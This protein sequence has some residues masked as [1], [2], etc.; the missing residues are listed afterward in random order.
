MADFTIINTAIAAIKSTIS[1]NLLTA[2]F[3]KVLTEFDDQYLQFQSWPICI[4]QVDTGSIK[5]NS[6][7]NI[8]LHVIGLFHEHQAQNLTKTITDTLEKTIA[9]LREGHPGLGMQQTT[10]VYINQ[11]VLDPFIGVEL[12]LLPP[13]GGF[14]LTFPNFRIDLQTNST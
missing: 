14:R 7:L 9:F 8:D 5:S 1:S 2:D 11:N 10:Q 3:K 13:L 4:I 12:P 6:V